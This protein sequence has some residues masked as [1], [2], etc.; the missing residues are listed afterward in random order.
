MKYTLLLFILIHGCTAHGETYLVPCEHDRSL[1][2]KIEAEGFTPKGVLAVVPA[3]LKSED[4]EVLEYKI[5]A[6]PEC[7]SLFEQA[8]NIIKENV[9]CDRT[10]TKVEVNATKKAAKIAEREAAQLEEARLAEL[11][12]T[13][14]EFHEAV[15][16]YIDGDNTKIQAIKKK[17]EDRKKTKAKN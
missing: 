8:V 5:V 10:I 15:L 3:E 17:I 16:A 6:D 7:D 2:C 12:Y 1:N 13:E 14:Q 4:Q 11:K 9:A